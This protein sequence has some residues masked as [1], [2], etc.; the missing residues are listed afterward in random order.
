[1][2]TSKETLFCCWVVLALVLGI[3]AAAERSMTPDL[4]RFAVLR[5]SKGT[6][7][8]T[9]DGKYIAVADEKWF[10]ETQWLAIQ[11]EKAFLVAELQRQQTRR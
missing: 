6:I 1:M 5:I 8:E 11:K 10:N 4:Y 2:S 7:I 3:A 9:M